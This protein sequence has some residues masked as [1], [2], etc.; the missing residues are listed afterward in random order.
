VKHSEYKG[1]TKMKKNIMGKILPSEIILLIENEGRFTIET[2]NN[3]QSISCN[4]IKEARRHYESI[5][6]KETAKDRKR[7]LL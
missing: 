5:V 3:Y 1:G 7:G 4:S 2:V 6:C